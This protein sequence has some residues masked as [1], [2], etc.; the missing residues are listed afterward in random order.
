MQE[1][2]AE[3]ATAE[4]QE[5]PAKQAPTEQQT[6]T[7]VTREAQETESPFKVNVYKSYIPLSSVLM[8]VDIHVV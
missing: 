3:Q 1:A 6:V 8:M 5:V 2:P 7:R 4:Q